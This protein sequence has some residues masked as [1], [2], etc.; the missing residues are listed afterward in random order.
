MAKNDVCVI[1]CFGG[2]VS[3][4]VSV[5]FV[6]EN[7]LMQ[8][9]RGGR[10]VKVK[11]VSKRSAKYAPDVVIVD[12]CSGTEPHWIRHLCHDFDSDHD[13]EY[14]TCSECAEKA[15]SGGSFFDLETPYCPW[16]GKMLSG[17]TVIEN[18]RT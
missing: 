3:I 12:V 2:I 8:A 14:C 15:C 13:Y 5:V 4:T 7:G 10:P 6:D 11:I 17:K 16:C 18:E 9:K 1:G